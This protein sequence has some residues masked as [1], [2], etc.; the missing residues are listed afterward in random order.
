MRSNSVSGG[1]FDLRLG[2]V[3]S[4]PHHFDESGRLVA[5]EPYV[6]EIRIWSD[7][8]REVVICAPAGS[9]QTHDIPLERTNVTFQPVHYCPDVSVR[10]KFRRV[11]QIPG[12]LSTTYKLI[13]ECDFVHLRSPSHTAFF[14]HLLVRMLNRSS[15]TKWAGYFGEFPGER[16]PRMIERK[17]VERVNM[18]NPVLVYGPTSLPHCVSFIPAFMSQAE[19]EHAKGISECR[20]W[21]APWQI[22]SVGRLTHGKGFDLA[23]R[24]LA[25]LQREHPELEWQFTQI[26]DGVKADELRNLSCEL[27]ISERVHFTGALPFHKVQEFYAKTH[28]L[29]MPGAEEGFPKTIPEAWAHGTIPIAARGG[30][31]PW[32]V[33]NNGAVFDPDPNSLAEGLATLLS[34]P[35][36]M[37]RMSHT[38]YACS[39]DLSLES[40]RERLTQVLT[41]QCRLKLTVGIA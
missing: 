16:A 28:V 3:S 23:L 13:R 31:T 11:Q 1:R 8:F 10:A 14:G 34:D 25:A 30:I 9:V 12:L 17:L 6:R 40:F 33:G 15:I 26:G 39:Q 27:G 22:L 20:T 18:R 41:S 19:L 38:L 32:I 5:Y 2:I 21:S 24:G 35:A 36:K 7:L 4:V 37:E 29:I